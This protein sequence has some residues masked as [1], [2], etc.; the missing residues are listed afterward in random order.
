MQ[1]NMKS[2]RREMKRRAR[3]RRFITGSK[4]SRV[5]QQEAQQLRSAERARTRT[6]CKSIVTP[7]DE[8]DI[9]PTRA[10]KMRAAIQYSN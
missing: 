10:L 4:T 2:A 8:I 6:A 3:N 1:R 7:M 9:M 5:R